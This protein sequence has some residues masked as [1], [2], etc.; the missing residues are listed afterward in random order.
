MLHQHDRRSYVRPT[1]A[2]PRM[3]AAAPLPNLRD[4]LARRAAIFGPVEVD[5]APMAPRGPA[6]ALG[7]L[8]RRVV[9]S[10]DLRRAS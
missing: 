1:P 10:L 2:P 8:A 4:A 9:A 6:Q 5:E 3:M 7:V